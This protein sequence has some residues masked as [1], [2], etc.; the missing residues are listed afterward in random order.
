MN[1]AVSKSKAKNVR[2]GGKVTWSELEHTDLPP[3]FDA[4]KQASRGIGSIQ[5][6]KVGT[7]AGN[8]CIASAAADGVPP[9][10]AFDAQIELASSAG[11]RRI[12][13]SEFIVADHRTIRRSDEILAAIIIPRT[14]E[15]GRSVFL[16]IGARQLM[17]TSIVTVA[18]LV[19]RDGIGRVKR[20]QI[21]IGGCSAVAQRLPEL[22]SALIGTVAEPGL[23]D[24]VEQAH[25]AKLSPIDDMRVSSAYRRDVSLT[26][27]RR[28]LEAC[29]G[30]Y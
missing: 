19:G 25:L 21:A 24:H 13:L 17:A 11:Q 26:L 4:L 30:V 5:I 10:L 14:I 1:S 23:S 8:L 12:R 6:R 27:V 22:E 15:I 28:A 9:L 18:A 3:S 16:K 2:I 29:V 7:I 20:A